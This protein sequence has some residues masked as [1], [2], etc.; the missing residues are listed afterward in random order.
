MAGSEEEE[1]GGAPEEEAP[2]PVVPTLGEA[3]APP[4]ADAKDAEAGDGAPPAAA[5]RP[6]W[7]PEKFWRL[8]DDG[9]GRPDVEAMAKSYRHLEARMSR[10]SGGGPDE[11]PDSATSYFSE[12]VVKKFADAAPGMDIKSVD[13]PMLQAFAR[14]AKANGLGVREAR[15]IAGDWI[16]EV[17]KAL[18]DEMDAAAEMAR[19]GPKGPQMVAETAKWVGG[20]RE[21]G[22]LS[23]AETAA[24]VAKG[25]SAEFV[26]A[27]FKLREQAGEKPVP[28]SLGDG[29]AGSLPSELE[30]RRRAGDY[31]KMKDPVYRAKVEEEGRRLFD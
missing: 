31:E 10:N 24:L 5:E 27:L 8:G 29:V 30:W 17:D 13:D 23:E 21:A 18:P 14:V 9:E 3:M 28:G 26:S 20:L 12:E 4:P 7:L 2:P 11:V 15:K 22:L 16:A 6:D 25:N 19:L 1:A